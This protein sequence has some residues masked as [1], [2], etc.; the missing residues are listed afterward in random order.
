MACFFLAQG[1][2]ID[3]LET[4]NLD[5]KPFLK[6]QHESELASGLA[7]C[8]QLLGMVWSVPLLTLENCFKCY[9]AGPKKAKKAPIQ[10][11]LMMSSR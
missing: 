9:E 7:R 5:G 10:L 11:E 4:C 3:T 2:G 8:N 6:T 1:I